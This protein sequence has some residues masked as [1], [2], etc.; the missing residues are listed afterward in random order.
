MLQMLFYGWL[1]W[2]PSGGQIDDFMFYS[3]P[4]ERHTGLYL[5]DTILAGNLDA[6]KDVLF[7]L[8]LPV[9]V[10]TFRAMGLVVRVTRT[11]MLEAHS[12]A[13][14]QTARAFGMSERRIVLT[15]AFRNTLP[16]VLTVVGLAAGELLAGS[17]LVESVFNWPGLGLYTLQ[18]IVAL[19]YPGVIGVSLILTVSYVVINLVI[20]LLYPA[21][22]PR[23]R[24]AS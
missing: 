2:L 16:A 3:S 13:Y 21:V 12:L 10:L 11:S 22:D 18:S 8:L 1:N 4:L 6:F 23:L 19:D 7:H 17:I 9:A 5:L 15:H 14:I 20:D 24:T